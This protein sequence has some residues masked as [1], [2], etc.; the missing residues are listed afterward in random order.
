MLVSSAP[1]AGKMTLAVLL[2]AR[3]GF[4]L[5]SKDVIKETL[6]DVF[7]D[8]GRKLAASRRIGGLC[9]KLIWS[10]VSHAPHSVLEANF[11]RAA[12]INDV[13]WLTLGL[14]LAK[15]IAVTVELKQP[16][17]FVNAQLQAN[18]MRHPLKEM[19]PEMLD[20]YDRPMSIG[21]IIEVDTRA[22]SIWIKCWRRC[23]AFFDVC[24]VT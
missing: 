22:Q 5:F 24:K 3:L 12:M 11:D 20:E 17:D 9:M 23:G 6:T 10:L 13:N 18:T 21:P 14:Q 19:P 16:G 15:Y 4:P 1:G 2:V 7:G 8:G